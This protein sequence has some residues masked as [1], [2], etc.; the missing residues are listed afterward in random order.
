MRNRLCA[1]LLLITTALPL[2]AADGYHIE[3]I[4]FR[5]G[6]MKAN[7][8]SKIAPDNWAH[9]SQHL[10]PFQLRSSLLET[11]VTKLKN[12]SRYTILLHRSWQQDQSRRAT[13]IALTS[14]DEIFGH[15]P[16]EGVL[17]LEQGQ[18]N[19]VNLEFWINQ[20]KADGNLERSEYLQQS[21]LAPYNE[22]TYIDYGDLG[23]L[24]KIQPQ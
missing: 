12:S 17:T 23:V 15:H 5:Q 16:I 13:R 2:W 19:K 21:A 3:L 1:F 6:D 8:H 22:L 11:P 14:G 7:Y 10:Q 24:I 20:F 9:K 4:I 18:S